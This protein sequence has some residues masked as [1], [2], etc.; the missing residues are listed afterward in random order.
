MPASLLLI[1]KRSEDE[2]LARFI[3]AG[4]GFPLTRLARPTE[5]SNFLVDHPQTI[6]FWDGQDPDSVANIAGALGGNISPFKVFVCT[7]GALN[8]SPHLFE[9][10]VFGH[11]LYR[12]YREPAPSV[13]SKLIGAALTPYPFGLLRFFPRGTTSQKI[14]IKKSGQKNAAVEAIRNFLMK[15]AV[16]SRLATLAAQAADEL[17]MNAIFDAPVRSDGTAFR[18]G[19]ARDADFELKEEGGIEVELA[20]TGTYTGLVVGDQ[21]GSFKKSELLKYLA[22]N[23]QE[24]AYVIRTSD[25]GAGLG[26]NGILQAG[27]S[28]AFIAKPGVR[29]EVM[30]LFPNSPNYKLFRSS[31]FRFISILGE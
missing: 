23:F 3:A 25:P 28:M 31:A 29:T 8:E 16:I 7:D 30:V 19:K 5:I 6:V 18:R 17:M 21:Y 12:R 9:Y 10:P 11:H 13:Y 22:K 15:Q 24:N 20:T 1:S 26:I 4:N 27:L 2:T 14:T